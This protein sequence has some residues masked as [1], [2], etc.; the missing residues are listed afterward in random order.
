MSQKNSGTS[1]LRFDYVPLNSWII[2]NCRLPIPSATISLR[3]D[4]VREIL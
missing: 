1:H 2:T 3:F 4:Y